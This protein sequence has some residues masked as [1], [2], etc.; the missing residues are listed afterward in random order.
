MKTKQFLLIMGTINALYVEIYLHNKKNKKVVE[1]IPYFLG[2]VTY[3]VWYCI[4]L[5]TNNTKDGCLELK[6]D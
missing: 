6:E 5:C 4:R 2:F 3:S 1:L